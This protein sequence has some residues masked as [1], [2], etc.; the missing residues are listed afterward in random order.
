MNLITNGMMSRSGRIKIQGSVT[1]SSSFAVPAG[2]TSVRLTGQGGGGVYN[3]A[4]NQMVY[5]GTPV[6]FGTSVQHGAGLSIFMPQFGSDLRVNGR[7]ET[8]RY[9]TVS[10]NSSGQLYV[11]TSTLY[12]DCS[13]SYQWVGPNSGAILKTFT[14]NE[15]LAANTQISISGYGR[16]LNSSQSVAVP[17][18]VFTLGQNLQWQNSAA[19][20]SAGTS[21]TASS[22]QSTNG[23]KTWASHATAGYPAAYAQTM[24]LSGAAATISYSVASGTS[25]QYDYFLT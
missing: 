14:A 3:A 20:Y 21:T 25:L 9:G 11:S 23:T 13:S 2:V 22:G 1:G 19:Y 7:S 6:A 5:G 10:L 24:T 18:A 15:T 17:A 8:A 4:V 12:A 16:D